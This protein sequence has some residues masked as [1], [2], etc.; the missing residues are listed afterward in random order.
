[1]KYHGVPE[2]RNGTDKRPVHPYEP[3][4]EDCKPILIQIAIQKG[5]LGD[6]SLCIANDEVQCTEVV[7]HITK[8]QEEVMCVGLFFRKV[9]EKE[10]YRVLQAMKNPIA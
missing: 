5:K 2:C 8:I 1:M 4:S 6:I 10:E 7:R 3:N 9:V